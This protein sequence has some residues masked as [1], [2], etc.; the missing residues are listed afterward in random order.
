MATYPLVERINLDLPA[1]VALS[2]QKH[3]VPV[4]TR[5]LIRYDSSQWQV[6]IISPAVDEAGVRDV[7]GQI[8]DALNGESFSSRQFL[9]SHLLVLGETQAREA[10]DRIRKGVTR[11]PSLGPYE[12]VDVYLVPDADKIEKQGLLYFRPAGVDVMFVSFAPLGDSLSFGLV[13]P[14]P[15]IGLGDLDDFLTGFS[16]YDTDKQKVLESINHNRAES[17]FAQTDLRNLYQKGL[18]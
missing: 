5:F 13:K 17:I 9:S 18:V 12:E 16:V 3:G 10:I 8:F 15:K 7:F 4:S 1:L 14:P 6:V 2:L 11:L